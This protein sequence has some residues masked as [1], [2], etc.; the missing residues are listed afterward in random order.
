MIEAHASS[1]GK[2]NLLIL[3]VDMLGDRSLRNYDLE[4]DET[5]S[6]IRWC[7]WRRPIR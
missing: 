1:T 7:F 3:G 6:T 2:G 4:G 5:R